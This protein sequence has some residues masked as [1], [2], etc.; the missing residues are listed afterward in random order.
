MSKGTSSKII[1]ITG[2]KGSGKTILCEWCTKEFQS[3]KF[4]VTGLLSVTDVAGDSRTKIDVKD[5]HSGE[6]RVLAEKLNS[7]D[8]SSMTPRW[9]FETQ[10]L[11]WGNEKLNACVP[12]D[13]LII[14]E[15]G[16]MEFIHDKGWMNAFPI[17]LGRKYR[18]ALVVIRP[19]LLA[20]AYEK[21]GEF[22]VFEMDVKNHELNRKRLDKLVSEQ[23][24]SS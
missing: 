19:Q 24:E 16:L 15:L 23:L 12:C 21:L 14:D 11:E 9:K 6:I 4:D 2:E 7:F 17:L 20:N 5:I 8:Y 22:Q 3:R 18:L 13:L 1:V 10:T